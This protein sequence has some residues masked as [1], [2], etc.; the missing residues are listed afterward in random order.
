MRVL[1]ANIRVGVEALQMHPLRTAL[2]VLGVLIGAAALIATMAVSDGM[3]TYARERVLR[4]TSVQ[5]VT[6]SPRTARYEDFTVALQNLAEQ[7][8]K[9]NDRRLGSLQR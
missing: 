3:M 8:V 2:S 5:V 6:L 7:L 4:D 9:L 1:A